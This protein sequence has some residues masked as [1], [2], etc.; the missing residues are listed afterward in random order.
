MSDGK[1]R[2]LALQRDDCVTQ[3][4]RMMSL[5]VD[6]NFG[7][8][9][10]F[11]ERLYANAGIEEEGREELAFVELARAKARELNCLLVRDSGDT[12]AGPNYQ[13]GLLSLG[14]SAPME[15]ADA[16]GIALSSRTYRLVGSEVQSP[17]D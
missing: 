6:E 15:Y 7:Q 9:V 4:R 8:P 12:V 1:H 16:C 13:G 2:M 14:C 3:A 5:L 11:L 17:E 10:L